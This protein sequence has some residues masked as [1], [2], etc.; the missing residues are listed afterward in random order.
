MLIK[1]EYNSGVYCNYLFN[2][3]KLHFYSFSAENI[4]SDSACMNF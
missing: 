1:H 2:I 4:A 3:N